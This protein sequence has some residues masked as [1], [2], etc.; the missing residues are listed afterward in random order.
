M[1]RSSRLYLTRPCLRRAGGS[2][3]GGQAGVV[4]PPD[5][6]WEVDLG[7]VIAAMWMAWLRRRLPRL[8]SRS[9]FV[10]PS[11]SSLPTSVTTGPTAMAHPENFASPGQSLSWPS[12]G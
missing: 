5:S 1:A 8:E 4:G 12:S 9:I 2:G 11:G 7:E 10:S 3:V 6:A